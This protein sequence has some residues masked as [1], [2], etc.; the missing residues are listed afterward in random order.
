MRLP[1]SSLNAFRSRQMLPEIVSTLIVTISLRRV[2]FSLI[3]IL[4][5]RNIAG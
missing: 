3:I 5:L 1:P 4:P 2:A